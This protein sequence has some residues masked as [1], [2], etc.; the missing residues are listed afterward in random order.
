MLTATYFIILATVLAN[1]GACAYFLERLGLKG[2]T[3]AGSGGASDE[4][5]IK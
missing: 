2:Q 4:L 1:G 3:L 5:P